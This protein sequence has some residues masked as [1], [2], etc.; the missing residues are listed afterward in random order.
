MNERLDGGEAILEAFRKLGVEYVLSS[1]GTEWAPVWEAVAK[2]IKQG[3]NGPRLLDCW[4]E[5][6]AVNVAAGYTLAT[7]RM[8]GVLLHAGSGLLQGSMGIH[9]ARVTGVPMVV[10]SGESMTYGENPAFDPG[11]QW[12]SNLSIPGGATNLVDTIVKYSSQAGSPHTVYESV[13][14]AGHAPGSDL[15]QRFDGDADGSMGAA[16]GQPNDPVGTADPHGARGH[17]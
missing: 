12:I 10:I 14:R 7:G 8:Q 1:P 3:K 11:G 13:I 4:H 6:L 17:R 15:S 9:G 5:T 16:R 2:Q